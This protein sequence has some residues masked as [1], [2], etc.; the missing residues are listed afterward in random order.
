MINPVRNTTRFGI[1]ASRGVQFGVFDRRSQGWLDV[2]L[3]ELR[4]QFESS[5]D[6]AVAAV[7]LIERLMEFD[8]PRHQ[9]SELAC[10]TAAA[11]LRRTMA[12]LTRI[13]D[14]VVLATEVAV[15]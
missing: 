7:Q 6:E 5:S 1:E 13:T 2:K 4:E 11:N 15:I 10:R 9:T 8:G 14:E 12:D 3:K